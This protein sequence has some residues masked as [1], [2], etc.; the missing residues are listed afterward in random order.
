MKNNSTL[1]L[2]S[3]LFIFLLPTPMGRIFIDMAGGIMIL[4]LVIALIFGGV[5]WLSLRDIKSKLK[6]CNQCGSTYFSNLSQC[7]I[8]GSS[9]TIE[10]KTFDSNMPASD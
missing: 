6:N 3:L 2:I 10:T 1:L 7:P 8:C 9:E 4:F 5:F